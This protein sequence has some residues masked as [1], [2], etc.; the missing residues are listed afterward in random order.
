MLPVYVAVTRSARDVGWL[1]VVALVVGLGAVA[2]ELVADVQMHRFV[3]TGS[4]AR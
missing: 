4:P 1:D 3:R 2:L